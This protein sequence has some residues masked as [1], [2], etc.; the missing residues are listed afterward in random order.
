MLTRRLLLAAG[1]ASFAAPALSQTVT[2]LGSEAERVTVLSDGGFE[3]PLSTLARDVP[4][5]EII[6]QAGTSDPFRTPLNV[7]CLR[8]GKDLILFDSGSGANFLPGS[9]RLQESLRAAGIEPEAV[10][11]VLFTHLH[12]DHFWGA[13]DEFDSPLFPNARW[14]AAA[15]E[16][17]F[18]TG[19]KAYDHLPAD[20]HAFAAGAQ[21]V[22]KGLADRLERMEAGREW[23]PG[24]A[25]V[26][27]AGHTPGHVSFEFRLGRSPVMVLGDALTHPRISFA[28][29]DWRPV[30]DQDADLA[31]AT[32]RRLLDKLSQDGTQVIG[33]HLPGAT[34]RVERQGTAYRFV[35][36]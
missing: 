10:T 14:L 36:A 12:P 19:A 25:A 22:A 9:G 28:H 34:G 6:A 27:T 16:I 1:A 3:M 33:Y 5:A 18:W 15:R 4:A 11:H 13:L 2:A 24:I 26:E 7:T 29:P 20:R 35:S 32:R 8:R 30:S 23:L 31:V 17:D 21:R